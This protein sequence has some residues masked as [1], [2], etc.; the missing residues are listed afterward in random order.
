MLRA[1]RLGV[2]L[3]NRTLQISPEGVS[4]ARLPTIES[5]VDSESWRLAIRV[6]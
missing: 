5:R 3:Y 6:I 2:S 4:R 1:P